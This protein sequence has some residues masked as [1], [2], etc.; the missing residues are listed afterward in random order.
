MKKT[1]ILPMSLVSLTLLITLLLSMPIKSF[2]A[3]P[4]INLGNASSF[5]VLAGEQVTNTGTTTINGSAGGDIGVYPGTAL[6][7]QSTM[8]FSGTI[9]LAD[10][11]AGLAKEAL[12]TAYDEAGSRSPVTV[13]P[14]ELGTKTIKPGVYTSE[15]GA[16]QITG[17]L[18]LDGDGDASSVFVF[19]T[20]STLITASNSKI[21]LIDGARVCNIFYR[22]GSSAT[23]GTNST[24]AGRIMASTS[25]AANTGATIYGQLLAKTGSVTLDANKISNLVCTS[26]PTEDGGE[27]PD[28]ASNLGLLLVSSLFLVLIGGV[29]LFASRKNEAK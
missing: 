13:I 15:T 2:A 7:G 6:T 14:A 8:T 27:L 29:G 21:N 4:T 5:A 20:E 1:R 11:T 24:F 10:A 26:A 9:H 23:L 28:T 22:V 18:T 3:T 12:S 16:F 17:T 25:I 19:I